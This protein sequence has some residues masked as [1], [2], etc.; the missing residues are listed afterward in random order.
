MLT[1]EKLGLKLK[2]ARNLSGIT[3]DAAASQC[4]ISRSKLIDIEKGNGPIDTMLLESLANLYGFSIS[5]FL[6]DDDEEENEVQLA[7]RASD[8]DDNDQAVVN[9]ARK[10]LSSIKDIEEV[11]KEID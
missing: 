7:F 10:V 8:L 3:Q 11:Y 1:R 5:Y 6:N 4:A 2:E 9:W